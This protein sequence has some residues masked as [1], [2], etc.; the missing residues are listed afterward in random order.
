MSGLAQPLTVF[1][2]QKPFNDRNADDMKCGD[3]D[4]KTLKDRFKLYQVSPFIDYC[5]YRSPY[6]H[7][8]LRRLAPY[9]KER[10]I[11]MLFNDMKTQSKAFSFVGTYKGIITRLIDHMHYK[12]GADY[13]DLQMNQAYKEA[14]LNDKS[15]DSMLNVIQE[16]LNGFDYKKYQLTS[17]AFPLLLPGG[18]CQN[19]WGGNPV[20]MAWGFQSTMSIVRRLL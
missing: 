2:S 1:T 15:D 19:L 13:Y 20:L 4:E 6:D 5:T 9:T 10:V 3:L 11:E 12:D 8:A 18:G 16:A 7:P 17:E 14:I